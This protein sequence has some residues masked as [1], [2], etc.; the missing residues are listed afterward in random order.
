[1]P[2]LQYQQGSTTWKRWLLGEVLKKDPLKHDG[3]LKVHI[4]AQIIYNTKYKGGTC[5]CL[6]SIV[7]YSQDVL[8]KVKRNEEH[9]YPNEM[10][11]ITLEDKKMNLKDK[12]K[13]K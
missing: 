7:I 6:C 1:M 12:I 3:R 2:Y 4:V 8:E 11:K 9:N 10:G 5:W 13:D